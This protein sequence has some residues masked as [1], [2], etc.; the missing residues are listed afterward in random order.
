MKRKP[1]EENFDEAEAQA[2]RLWSS[3][4][5]PKEIIDLFGILNKSPSPRNEAFYVLLTA[6]QRFTQLE[7]YKGLLPLSGAL[8]DMR[9]DTNGWAILSFLR[10]LTPESVQIHLSATSIQGASR[11]R[12]DSVHAAR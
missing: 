9:A 1:D 8:P 2:W 10:V 12:E 6:L 11:D 5:V 7:E 4:G 3:S